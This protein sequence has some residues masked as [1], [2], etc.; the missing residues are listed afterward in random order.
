MRTRNIYIASALLLATAFSS[1]RDENTLQWGEGRMTLSTSVMSDIKVVSREL[2]ETQHNELAQS[3][4][5]WITKADGTLLYKYH[6]I[7]EFPENGLPLSTG[8]YTAKGWIGDSIPASWNKIRYNGTQNFTIASG[9]T[10]AVKLVCKVRN[11][12]VSVKLAEKLDDV[13]HDISFT[14]SLNDGI[15]DGSHSLVFSGDTLGMKGYFM[16]NSH[17]DG[18]TWTISGTDNTGK[19]F[20][21]SGEYRDEAVTETPRLAHATE[22]KFNI[23]YDYQQGEIEIGGAFLDID[24]DPE[25]VEGTNEEIVMALAPEIVGLDGLDISKAILGEPGAVGRKSIYVIG[26]N[27]LKEVHLSGKDLATIFT[28]DSATAVD[29]LNKEDEDLALLAPAGITYTAVNKSGDGDGNKVTNLRLNFEERFANSLATGMHEFTIRAVD[30]EGKETTKTVTV[31]VSDAPGQL[32]DA[33]ES[34]MTCYTASISAEIK[35]GK[36]GKV[37]GFNVIEASADRSYDKWT[38]VEGKLVGNTL[39]AKLTGLSAGTIYKYRLVVDDYE[40]MQVNSFSTEAA[41]QLPNSSFEDW[42]K[43]GKVIVPGADYS[44]TFWDSGNHGSATMS[45]N[46]TDSSTDYVHSGTYSAKLRSQFVGVMGIGKFAAGNIFAGNYLYTDGTDGELG[47]GRAFTGRPVAVRLWARYEPGIAGDKGV[48]DY[49]KKGDADTGII[50]VALTDDTLIK[51]ETAKS[52]LKGTS[53]PCVVKTKEASRQLFNKNAENVIAY[54]EHVFST[55][56]AGNGLVSIE[57]PMEY[58]RTGV[59]PSYIIFVA[60]ASR[61]GDYFEGGE[62]STMYLD[63]IELVYE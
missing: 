10:T 57:I 51:Y 36:A 37:M 19:Q 29:L 62:G 16:P 34:V 17:T 45:V 52:D 55:A 42:S 46:I 6:G 12:L 61:Y 4:L 31:N 26:A 18:F 11:A 13:L 59:K 56:T 7:G 54:G 27:P 8:A 35:E 41:A 25:P 9:E 60:S 38:F 49:V 40:S 2:S 33:D 48:G 47:W 24:V 32:N 53:W 21:R 63:D 50:Y 22:Y 14:V 23:N 1:C 3:A 43:T 30:T 15:T 39:T 20:T 44:T 5:I 58:F 28:K